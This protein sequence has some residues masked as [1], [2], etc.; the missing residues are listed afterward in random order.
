[1]GVLLF[2]LLGNAICICLLCL[3]FLKLICYYLG[4]WE[5]FFFQ[6]EN[7]FISPDYIYAYIKFQVIHKAVKKKKKE[8]KISCIWCTQSWLGR[9]LGTM[10]QKLSWVLGDFVSKTVSTCVHLTFWW[11]RGTHTSKVNWQDSWS[12]ECF[13]ENAYFRWG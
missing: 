10:V 12:S 2:G 11:G 5:F 8:T 13:K 6:N 1:M 7:S 4:Q 9:V 3:H